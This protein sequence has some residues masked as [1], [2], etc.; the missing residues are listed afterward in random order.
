MKKKIW[1]C[2][3]IV[4]ALIL[5]IASKCYAISGINPE[6]LKPGIKIDGGLAGQLGG[7]IG[8][9][10]IVGVGI[11]AIAC[12]LLGIRYVLSSVEDKAE[13]KKKI[14]PY[15]LGVLIFFCATGILRMIQQVA[16]WLG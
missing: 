1:N 12:V 15:V 5:V 6:Q 3:F 16:S 13:I 4:I 7:V 8:I 9:V 14:F 10:Q 2:C 11:V